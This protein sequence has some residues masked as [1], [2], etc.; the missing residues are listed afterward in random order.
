MGETKD[1]RTRIIESFSLD[2]CP[3]C[4]MLRRDELDI[5]YRWIGQSNNAAK[6][7]GLIRKI[8]DAGGFCN[9]HFWRFQEMS[10]HYAS[11]NIGAQLIDKL[12]EILRTNKQECP[13]NAL[14]YREKTSDAWL[15][16]CPLCFELREKE[17]G[18]LKELLAI[19]KHEENRLRYENSCGLCIPHYVRVI[20]YIDDDSL[21]GFLYET[22]IS[23]LEGIKTN[24]ESFISKRHPSQRWKQTEDEKKVWF[25]AIEKITGRSRA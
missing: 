17:S 2:G 13:G 7:S 3:L 24:A 14:K 21:M 5:L 20:E 10:T 8:L 1:T 16:E 6:N 19:L 4:S 9:F 18:Y 11:A 12:L 25:Q 23:Q 15:A 22:Q